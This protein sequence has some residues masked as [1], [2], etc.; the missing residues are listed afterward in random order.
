MATSRLAVATRVPRW[1]AVFGAVLA[2]VC[3]AMGMALAPASPVA[4]Q[5][6]STTDS[7]TTT[8]ELEVQGDSQF[9]NILPRPN[10]GRAPDSPNDPGGWQQYMVFALI[11]LGLL[12]I[13]LL[14]T[15]Q[16]R[17]IRRAQ[18]RYP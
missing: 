9:G 5:E 15:R 10:S 14:A 17:K 16:S 13:V 7:S 1:L 12:A 4:A 6:T 8:T 11:G 3:L 18:G 2:L